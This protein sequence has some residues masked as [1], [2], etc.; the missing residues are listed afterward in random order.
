MFEIKSKI[1]IETRNSK[2]ETR[3]SKLETRNSETGNW[4]L[5]TGNWKLANLKNRNLKLNY[6]IQM[7]TNVQALLLV[8]LGINVLI[9]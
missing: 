1:K 5:E 6:F 4:K 8:L 3:N 7:L 9:L 2:L